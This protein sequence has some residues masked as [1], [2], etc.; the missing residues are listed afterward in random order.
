MWIYDEMIQMFF[1]HPLGIDDSYLYTNYIMLFILRYFK[2]CICG[3]VSSVITVVVI[4]ND[5]SSISS[6][7]QLF[8]DCSVLSTLHIVVQ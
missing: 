3:I 1:Y 2:G 8:C 4:N 7:Y 6:L 5:D